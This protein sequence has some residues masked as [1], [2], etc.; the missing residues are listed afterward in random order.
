MEKQPCPKN[1]EIFELTID[2]DKLKPLKLLKL[3]GFN[4]AK[5]WRYNGEAVEGV[6]TRKFMI[7]P[8]EY[9]NYCINFKQFMKELHA[10]GAIPQG[11][12]IEPFRD[13]YFETHT[14]EIGIAS[15]NWQDPFGSWGYPQIDR[16]GNPGFKNAEG[17]PHPHSRWIVFAD[18]IVKSKF[19]PTDIPFRLTLGNVSPLSLPQKYGYDKYENWVYDGDTVPDGT[20][21]WFKLVRIPRTNPLLEHT[22][23]ELKSKLSTYGATPSVQWLE[24]ITSSFDDDYSYIDTTSM[25]IANDGFIS[26]MGERFL[27]IINPKDGELDQAHMIP[28]G[29]NGFNTST[30]QQAQKRSNDNDAVWEDRIRW[31]VPAD[32]PK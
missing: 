17:P 20:T 31:L 8:G 16:R 11:Q 21:G 28:S 29:K 26:P 32:E 23:E 4:Y 13:K 3:Y 15:P 6:Q 25:G 5:A 10:H 9:A 27:P 14:A 30:Q 12:W 1:F 18:T 2:G 19:P 7:V 24:A 22:W